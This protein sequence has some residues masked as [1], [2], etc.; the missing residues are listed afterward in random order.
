MAILPFC[1]TRTFQ[2][3]DRRRRSQRF[4]VLTSGPSATVPKLGRKIFGT[5]GDGPEVGTFR[6][7]ECPKVWDIGTQMDIL[8]IHKM[9][10]WP[11]LSQCTK[12]WDRRQPFQKLT[13]QL[14]D[15]RR[16]SQ[17]F[18]VLTSGPSPTVPKFGI[19]KY[20]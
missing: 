19:Y 4:D 17:R 6:S 5:V 8:A 9:G 12:L 3:R 20:F 18:Y 7:L 13:S 15:R 2:L 16:R 1:D 10:N 11:F 14:R